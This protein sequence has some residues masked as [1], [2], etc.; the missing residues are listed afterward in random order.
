MS[1]EDL[2]QR[3]KNALSGQANLVTE[4]DLRQLQAP[5]SDNF[6]QRTAGTSW[7]WGRR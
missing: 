4:A 5:R 7:R 6:V 2:D 1:A 3:I